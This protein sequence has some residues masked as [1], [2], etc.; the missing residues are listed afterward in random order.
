MAVNTPHHTHR[1]QGRRR[2][3]RGSVTSPARRRRARPLLAPKKSIQSSAIVLPWWQGQFNTSTVCL[4]EVQA[5]ASL[6]G[7]LPDAASPR[8]WGLHSLRDSV[9]PVALRQPPPNTT[10]QSRAERAARRA[11]GAS[12]FSKKG[13]GRE[14]AAPR[15]ARPPSYAPWGVAP[16]SPSVNHFA[17]EFTGMAEGKGGANKETRGGALKRWE[18]SPEGT[19]PPKIGRSAAAPFTQ[20]TVLPSS[21]FCR[22]LLG[23][24]HGPTASPPMHSSTAKSTTLNKHRSSRKAKRFSTSLVTR[25]D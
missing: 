4:V 13:H 21:L 8:R 2:P 1:E 25:L 12:L 18:A 5:R 3:R 20:S 19:L 15:N 6:G 9:A 16:L 22:G 14:R 7:T 24:E 17:L 23:G 11:S 10:P